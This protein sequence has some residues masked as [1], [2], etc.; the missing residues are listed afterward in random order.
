MTVAGRGHALVD[1]EPEPPRDER[2]G[3]APEVV[4]Q[5]RHPHPAQLEH[6]AEAPRR[7]DGRPCASLLEHG[8]RRDRRPVDH[9]GDGLVAED[10]A[11][12][13]DDGAVVAGRRREHL[14]EPDIAR[15]GLQHDVRER[16]ADVGAD[17]HTRSL[18]H[19]RRPIGASGHA[20]APMLSVSTGNV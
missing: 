19:R 20:T 17:A 1:L 14:H 8:V 15:V 7:H 16:S 11:D 5:V 6:V 4:V 3:L 18:T 13:L 2:L 12:R 10:L 9:L